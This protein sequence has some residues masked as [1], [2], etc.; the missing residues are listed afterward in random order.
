MEFKHQSVL[1]E[2]TIR[3][4]RV[5]PD[6][7]YVD[8]TL[9]GGGHSYAVCQQLSAKGSLIGIDQDEAAIKAAGERLKEFGE[10]VTI[11]RSNYCNMKKELQKIGI[12][13]ECD[14][15]PQQLLQHEKR[16]T[17][18]RDHIGRWDHFRFGGIFLPAGQQG[19]RL[20]I[21]GRCPS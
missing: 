18:D 5:K 17:K 2:E 20:Y 16:I 8:G 13:S 12:T 14:D 15:H 19:E 9:G 4:L 1:L 10:N 3:N 21:Q 11:I 6:G 7:I